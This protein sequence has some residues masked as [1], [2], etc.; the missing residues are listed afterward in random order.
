MNY[1]SDPPRGVHPNRKALSK[2]IR[3]VFVSL[4]RLKWTS[5]ARDTAC[6]WQAALSPH[7]SNQNASWD[8][9]LGPVLPRGWDRENPFGTAYTLVSGAV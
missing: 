7:Y 5:A 4:S 8:H 2:A 6:S 3:V 1:G 9:I